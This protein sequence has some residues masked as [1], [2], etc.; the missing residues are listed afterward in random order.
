MLL[1]LTLAA[2]ASSAGHLSKAYPEKTFER[3]NAEIQKKWK[4][5]REPRDMDSY[6]RCVSEGLDIT[7]IEATT[8]I[9]FPKDKEQAEVVGKCCAKE[10]NGCNEMSAVCQAWHDQETVP[11]GWA[12]ETTG[13]FCDGICEGYVWKFKKPEYCPLMLTVEI[14]V[15]VAV[16]VGLVIIITI[17]V[18]QIFI[19]RSECLISLISRSLSDHI[20]SNLVYLTHNSPLFIWTFS[21][22][23][24]FNSMM[25]Y[26]YSKIMIELNEFDRSKT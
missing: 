3:M 11:T 13:A 23:D 1:G 9:F 24:V 22:F 10:E 17:I 5:A 25:S 7:L 26:G 2:V 12:P 21:P 15:L 20:H 16:I 19:D 6:V 8:T 14:I 4:D 18:C